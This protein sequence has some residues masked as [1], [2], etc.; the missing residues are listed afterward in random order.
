MHFIK[1]SQTFLLVTLLPL[2][3]SGHLYSQEK[4]TQTQIDR[5]IKERWNF[6]DIKSEYLVNGPEII[7]VIKNT[8][9]HEIDS[10]LVIG[11]DKIKKEKWGEAKPWF[12]LI[13]RNDPNNIHANYGY[14]I[15]L[16]EFYKYSFLSVVGKLV[17]WPRS[18]K[19]FE[20]VIALDSTYKDVFY[21]YSLLEKH[22]EHYFQSIQLLHN[23]ISIKKLNSDLLISLLCLYDVMI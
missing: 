18:Q 8:C 14:A 22:R 10:M 5:I 11:I 12:E 7:K 13:L 15:C 20:R 9:P 21:Q 16:R 3:L 17:N 6:R 23:H 4:L 1:R 2:I 19:Y